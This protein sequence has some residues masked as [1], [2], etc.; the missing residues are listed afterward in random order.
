MKIFLTIT[1]IFA[2][3]LAACSETN[4]P[5]DTDSNLRILLTDAPLPIEFV[6]RADVTF[7]KIEIKKENENEPDQFILVEDNLKTINLLDLRNG[8]TAVKAEADAPATSYKMIR[9]TVESAMIELKDDRTFDLDVPPNWIEI[10]VEPPFIVDNNSS[11]E[12]LLDF[13]VSNS[14]EVEGDPSRIDDVTG[15]KFDPQIRPINM[16]NSGIIE[17]IVTYSADS[18]PVYNA[19]IWLEGQTQSEINTYTNE[20]GEYRI[21]GVPAGTF[22]I[23][24]KKDGY[25]LST[26]TD[27]SIESGETITINFSIVK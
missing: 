10:T 14:F 12:L 23:Y 11:T 4:S 2:L 18:S 19:K 16:T 22:D 13:D 9:L 26:E 25:D 8:A 5:G 24:C 3:A 20:Q 15:F 7:S 1:V 17:G 21:I 27:I 6:E